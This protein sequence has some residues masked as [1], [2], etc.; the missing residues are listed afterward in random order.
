MSVKKVLGRNIKLYRKLKGFT[1]EEFSERLN[2]NSKHVS[3][4]EVGQKYPSSE[5]LDAIA[6]ELEVPY[7]QL[8][9]D[10]EER[11]KRISTFLS[12]YEVKNREFISELRETLN[13]PDN[14]GEKE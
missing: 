8:F 4:I 6:R 1:Q 14:D 7:S 3:A 9:E 13:F 11:G 10:P 12:L 5:L 2:I